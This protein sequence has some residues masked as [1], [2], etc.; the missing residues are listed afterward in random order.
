VIAPAALILALTL[1]APARAQPA[2]PTA[3]S[4]TGYL[5]AQALLG[6]RHYTDALDK[7]RQVTAARP[8]FAPGWFARALAARRAGQCAD[9]IP[10]YRRYA[11]LQ[12]AE[13]EPYFGLGLCLR[14]TGDRPGAAAALRR[15]V[16]LERRPGQETWIETARSLI[17]GLEAAAPA[18]ATVPPPTAAPAP[19]LAS[20]GRGALAYDEAQRLRDGGQVE[21]ALKKFAEAVALDPDLVAARAAWGELLIKFHREAQAAVVLQAAVARSPQYPLT[22]YELGFA[23]RETRRFAEAVEAYR[24]YI[25]LRPSDPDPHYGVARALQRMGRDA[26]AARSFAT[27]VAMENRAGEERWVASA[28]TQIAALDRARVNRSS[29]AAS[30]SPTALPSALPADRAPAPPR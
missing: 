17:A 22:W 15:F 21:P 7:L 3:A 23:L 5:E 27:Y 8:D 18:T 16:E 28:K 26:E 10:A 29:A 2:A 1:P 4:P 19:A 6:Q 20:A 13:A 24:R 30:A 11:T 25:A 12:P 9:A 14:D